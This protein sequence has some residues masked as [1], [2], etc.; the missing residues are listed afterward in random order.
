MA[1]G[2]CYCEKFSCVSVSLC[3]SL[4]S[5]EYLEKSKHLQEQLKELKSE[6]DVLKVDDKQSHMDEIHDQNVLHGSSKYTS[7]GRVCHCKLLCI[8]LVTPYIN[9]VLLLYPLLT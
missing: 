7:I 3:G 6:I 5:A 8:K 4:S 9:S 2:P 1:S